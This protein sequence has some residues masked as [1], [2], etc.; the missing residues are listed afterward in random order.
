MDR[1]QVLL[2]IKELLSFLGESEIS[3]FLEEHDVLR[4]EVVSDYFKGIHLTKRIDTISKGILP[5]STT[6]LINY[7]LIINPLTFNEVKFGIK[8]TETTN[9]SSTGN[10]GLVAHP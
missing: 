6:T 1:E 4:L 2:K 9:S 8:E 10:R 3:L 5:Y 7:D